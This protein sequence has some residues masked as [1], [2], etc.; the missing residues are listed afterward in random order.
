MNTLLFAIALNSAA[1]TDTLQEQMFKMEA[2]CTDKVT[3]Q[4]LCETKT[5]LSFQVHSKEKSEKCLGVLTAN[6]RGIT[7]LN[8]RI[9]PAH[10]AEGKII[11]D[12]ILKAEQGFLDQYQL[13][14]LLVRAKA[15]DRNQLR[16]ER[17]LARHEVLKQEYY[18]VLGCKELAMSPDADASVI[19]AIARQKYRYLL[20]K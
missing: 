11:D 5:V 18:S 9:W 12:L 15:W 3:G 8:E 16:M 2:L 4:K 19:E 14:A 13:E 10:E 20:Q 6:R 1:A 7:E 17:I